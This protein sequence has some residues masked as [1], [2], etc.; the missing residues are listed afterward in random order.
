M[1]GLWKAWKAK[2]RL[3]TLST[4]PLEISP[5]GGEIP[6][7][8]QLRRRG[9]MEKWKTKSRFPASRCSWTGAT[10]DLR[11]AGACALKRTA[12]TSPEMSNPKTK[13]SAVESRICAMSVCGAPQTGFWPIWGA[14]IKPAAAGGARRLAPRRLEAS[15]F[16]TKKQFALKMFS[17]MLESLWHAK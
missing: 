7:F 3:P 12:E 1:P 10:G 15:G 4:S 8:P 17:G 5:N 9:R 2:S 11:A 16:S 13:T 6:T 14:G